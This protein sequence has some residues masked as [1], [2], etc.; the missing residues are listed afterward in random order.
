MAD[1]LEIAFAL[2]GDDKVANAFLRFA[3]TSD[4]AT[5]SAK[6]LTLSLNEA[7]DAYRALNAEAARF[8]RGQGGGPVI[9]IGRGVS[10]SAGSGQSA[11]IA[12]RFTT[13]P[14]Q[15]QAKLSEEMR[16]ASQQGNTRAVSDIA[17]AQ[18]RNDRLVARAGAGPKHRRAALGPPLDRARRIRPQALS[19]PSEDGIGPSGGRVGTCQ[20]TAH[21]T[22]R[23]TH[24][25]RQARNMRHTPGERSDIASAPRASV[26]K[27][28][29]PADAPSESHA[30]R[31]KPTRNSSR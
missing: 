8:N 7:A 18:G 11:A 14:F 31:L 15:R 28:G 29:S 13:G 25:I 16:R 26:A 19:G 30:P 9:N 21:L 3:K 1:T 23:Q 5:A 27:M 17:L 20:A 24:V 2:T 6:A 10:R 4:V 12:D 22:H